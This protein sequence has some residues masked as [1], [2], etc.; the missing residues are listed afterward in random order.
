MTEKEKFIEHISTMNTSFL[1]TVLV[2][3][4]YRKYTNDSFIE[5]LNEKFTKLKASGNTQL[6]VHK[7]I[8]ICT[9]NKDKKVFCFV[10]NVTKDY[11]T[12]SYLEDEN[13]YYN[14]HTSCSEVLYKNKPILNKF[15]YFSIKP[16][17]TSAYKNHNQISNPIQEY[18]TF[19]TKDFCNMETI[20]LWLKKHKSNY[21]LTVEQ[22]EDEK[23]S[24]KINQVELLVKKEFEI[25]YG[26]LNILS[27]LYKKEPY[28]KQQL[29]VY[30]T[31]KDSI[32]QLKNW[33]AYQDEHKNEYQLF[34]SVF[35]DN[36]ELTHY[37]L[38]LDKIILNPDNFKHTLKYMSIIE[39]AQAIE[40]TGTIKS[41]S[42]LEII[43]QA[44]GRTYSKREIV[45]SINDFYSSDY[46]ISFSQG[47]VKNLENFSVGQSVKVLARLTG[48]EF[49]NT[50]GIKDFK[51][52]LYGWRVEKLDAKPE[53]K[54]NTKEMD[55]YY[56]YILLPP[57]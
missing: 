20:E 16:E 47:R 26:K 41:I 3:N 11:F 13:K 19:C 36:R 42:D 28:F 46:Q 18:K 15:N 21:T 2:K 6:K 39:D 4:A 57:F 50:E 25:L 43:K 45:L 44:H 56:K 34:S 22:L 14:F 55:L 30:D 1:E 33:F 32:S 29:E 54:E 53:I 51:Y 52:N 40:F 27:I 37:R 38:E 10:G 23:N 12:L 5:K 8:G 17:E 7:G 48:G 24:F 9:C 31:V 49:E 35:Y